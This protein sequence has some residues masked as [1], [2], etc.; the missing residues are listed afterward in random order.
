M[1]VDGAPW[2]AMEYVDGSPVAEVTGDW[3]WE[4]TRSFLVTVLDAL[5]H[6]HAREIVHRDLKPS[7]IL[8]EGASDGD[9]RQ[10]KLVDFGIA[11]VFDADAT[12]EWDRSRI[13]GTPEFM[14]PEQIRGDGRD[15][16]PWT[17]LY[18]L[19]CMTWQIVS[20]RPPYRGDTTEE[21]L[22]AHMQHRPGAFEPRFPVP[23]GLEAWMRDLMETDIEQRTRRAA[24]AAWGLLDLAPPE[25]SET[26]ESAAT[27]EI[28]E[29]TVR[30]DPTLR[31][32][33]ETVADAEL[34]PDETTAVIEPAGQSGTINISPSDEESDGA[35]DEER[36][37]PVPPNWERDH[38]PRTAAILPK[39]GLQLFGLREVPMVDRISERDRLWD[40]LR[41]VDHRGGPGMVTLEAGPGTGK[42]RLA[43]WVCRRAHELGA[44]IV[45]RASHAASS[46]P[47]DGLRELVRR[48]FRLSGLGRREG[49]DRLVARLPALD[50]DDAM[51]MTDARA[52]TELVWPTP[53][54]APGIEGPR[55]RFSSPAQKYGL[56]RRLLARMATR[57]RVIVWFDDLQWGRESID[58]L[59]AL[60]EAREQAPPVL[61]VATLRSDL[62]AERPGRRDRIRAL[63]EAT[64][65]SRIALDPL[66]ADDQRQ[67]LG[68]LLDLDPDFAE[69]LA[70]RTEGHPLFAI[71]LLRSWVDRGLIEESREGFRLR[72]E[73]DVDIPDDIHELWLERLRRFAEDTTPEAPEIALQTL[74][75]AAALGREIAPAEWRA[76]CRALDVEVGETMRDRLFECGLVER[77]DAGWAFAHGLLVDSLERRAREAGRW[78]DHHRR[79]ANI[80]RDLSVDRPRETAARRAD[81]W[82]QA[83]EYARAI[84]PLWEEF[85]RLRNAGAV[86]QVSDLLERRQSLLEATGVPP[87]DPRRIENDLVLQSTRLTRGES[88][89]SVRDALE[90][91]RQ[92]AVECG[93][94]RLIAKAWR[95]LARCVNRMGESSKAR[96]WAERAV[97]FARECGDDAELADTL[98]K[99]GWTEHSSGRIAEAEKRF[100]EAQEMAHRAG[101]HYLEL[102]VRRGIALAAHTRGMRA[103]ARVVYE[104]VLEA[105]REAGYRW[106]EAY[107]LNGLGELARFDEDGERARTYYREFLAVAREF[108]RPES[109][110][111]THLNL[112]QVE[113]MTRRFD[114]ATDHL[115]EAESMLADID[116]RGRRAHLLDLAWLT[117]AAGLADWA[118]LDV[119]FAPFADGWPE[120][121]RLIKDHPWLLEMAGERE[122]AERIWRLARQLRRRLDDPE[123]AER[124]DEKIDRHT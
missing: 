57:R 67:L 65:A 22:Q 53:D 16:G 29:Q 86:D 52:L 37:P 118:A 91:A 17:D 25:A 21:V 58:M 54:D 99:A 69:R 41:R 18:A 19:G 44:A 45:M 97:T 106:L 56:V 113:L 100:D 26:D 109:M 32:L 9:P 39:A 94:E 80:L 77:T 75:S 11:R 46:A 71:Q 93:D 48:A 24:D 82:I 66:G 107:C 61:V 112:A 103:R 102:A 123:A 119:R 121:A 5:A 92:R 2:F 60:F 14:A 108:N 13:V 63:F 40:E 12:E 68:R 83:G 101:D 30:V 74:E 88:P 114:R 55:Y 105:T 81:H 49:F 116:Q 104:D 4:A 59:Q 98:L 15:Q 8:I 122:R 95:L 31:G 50:G 78:R 79:C 89:E 34:P 96:A 87:D 10:I 47:D 64:D 72:A 111:L 36:G 51:R 117:R 3:R 35:S 38:A 7:N 110:A 62:V 76:L 6:A 70:G 73:A 115:E 28:G 20:G 85:E 43:Q 27:R 23:D 1:F 33:E 42:T 124:L 120:D 84:A 90:E